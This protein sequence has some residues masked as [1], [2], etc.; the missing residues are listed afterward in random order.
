MGPADPFGIGHPN[1]SDR[2]SRFGI[3]L[4]EGTGALEFL[5]EGLRC[6]CWRHQPVE[7]QRACIS[8][9]VEIGGQTGIQEFGE[10]AD[11][12]LL[13]RQAR[14]HGMTAARNEQSFGLGVRNGP[15]EID[16]RHGT[17]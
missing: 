3:A 9:L 2:E 16:T 12:A 17:A 1:R 10:I 4:S 5:D 14:R 6:T 7:L 13:D 11:P 8:G 15:P